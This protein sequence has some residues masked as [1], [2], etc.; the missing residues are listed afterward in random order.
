MVSS[1]S[2][3]C[4]QRRDMWE[5]HTRRSL[6]SAKYFYK[7]QSV[8]MP[9][10]PRKNYHVR[11]TICVYYNLGAVHVH[12]ESRAVL[13][14]LWLKLCRSELQISGCLAP[15]PNA[16]FN[17]GHDTAAHGPCPGQKEP[18]NPC[19]KG[20]KPAGTHLIGRLIGPVVSSPNCIDPIFIGKRY[21]NFLKLLDRQRGLLL[22]TFWI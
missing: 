11:K 4:L 2:Q 1:H 18:G 22:L 12:C 21:T 14:S 10:L 15:C 19:G 13:T 7:Y 16:G 5:N 9:Y 20:N 8:T 17:T 3:P 6:F